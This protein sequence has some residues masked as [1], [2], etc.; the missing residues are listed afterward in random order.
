MD[1]PSYDEIARAA[2]ITIDWSLDT[3]ERPSGDIEVVTAKLWP[4]AHPAL[5]ESRVLRDPPH[6]SLP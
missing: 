2:G 6:N 5:Q 1:D 3:P 4:E